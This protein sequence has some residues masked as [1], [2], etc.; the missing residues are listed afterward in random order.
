MTGQSAPVPSDK[1]TSSGNAA[2]SPS[3]SQLRRMKDCVSRF[4]LH[5][6][7]CR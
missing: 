2:A 5:D 3:L 1:V 7:H 4:H 6:L